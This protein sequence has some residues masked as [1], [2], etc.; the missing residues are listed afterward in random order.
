MLLQTA[1]SM[2]TQLWETRGKAWRLQP[3]TGNHAHAYPQRVNVVLLWT[4]H[5]CSLNISKV[6][7]L[8][9]PFNHKESV[10]ARAKLFINIYL[11]PRMYH[12]P[13]ST[14]EWSGYKFETLTFKLG[15]YQE[16][17]WH[18]IFDSNLQSTCLA[19][20]LKNIYNNYL[21]VWKG[22]AGRCQSLLL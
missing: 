22:R 14:Q 6:E 2:R 9:I 13:G 12:E 8:F 1:C 7:T 20:V 18:S 4:S 3:Y 5:T 16:I 11:M 17:L 15:A 10:I 21:I 19:W